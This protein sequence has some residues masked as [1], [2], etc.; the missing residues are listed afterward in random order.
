MFTCQL[1]KH[2]NEYPDVLELPAEK[3]LLYNHDNHAIL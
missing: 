3:R 2:N 1:K